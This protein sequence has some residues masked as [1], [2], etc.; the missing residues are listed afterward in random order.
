[1][2]I[3]NS[4]GLSIALSSQSGGLGAK[5]GLYAISL[6]RPAGNGSCN[7]FYI[8]KTEN[9]IASCLTARDYKGIRKNFTCIA[10]LTP[11]KINKRQNGRR[12]KES[13][14]PMFTLTAQDKHG[15]LLDENNTIRIRRLTPLECFRLQGFPDD[16][17][18]R[19]KEVGVSDTQLYKQVGN[20]I[21]VNVIKEIAKNF[22]HTLYRTKLY[23]KVHDKCM[24][25]RK[26]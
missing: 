11:D 23:D 10:V 12:F 15:I 25:N 7:K 17:Y 8:K 20:S 18:Y 19:A 22:Y 5:T 13:N 9:K 1:M 14:E 24:I 2:R 4:R 6:N 21:T 3:Y 16:F 26:E